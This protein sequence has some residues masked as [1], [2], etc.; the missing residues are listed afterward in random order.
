M[1]MRFIKEQI[2]SK[3]VYVFISLFVLFFFCKTENSKL[4]NLKPAPTNFELATD[5]FD[6]LELCRKYLD[7]LTQ[8]DSKDDLEKF[9]LKSRKVFKKLEPVL[10]F[11][12]IENYTFFNAPN[13]LKIEEEDATDIKIR[14]PKSF[15][16]LEESIFTDTLDIAAIHKTGAS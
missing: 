14:A 4:A 15:Q 3:E 7:S 6:R 5:Y 9:Y 2:N 13:I 11:H 10:A 16:V 12:D 1:L 8:T